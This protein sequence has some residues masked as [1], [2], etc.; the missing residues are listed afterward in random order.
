MKHKIDE[1]E[2]QDKDLVQKIS[3]L[4]KQIEELKKNK[5]QQEQDIIE[6]SKKVED[7]FQKELSMD[8]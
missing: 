7:A 6:L 2:D 1:Y 3:N 5:L 8:K 4:E